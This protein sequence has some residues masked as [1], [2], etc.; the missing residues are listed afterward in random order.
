M[1]PAASPASTPANEQI[2]RICEKTD[3]ENNRSKRQN[4]VEQ[5]ADEAERPTLA[6]YRGSSSRCRSKAKADAP[7]DQR[8]NERHGSWRGGSAALAAGRVI[9]RSK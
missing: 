9:G 8:Q 7:G 2:G 4:R 3:G 5:G 6:E 1:A